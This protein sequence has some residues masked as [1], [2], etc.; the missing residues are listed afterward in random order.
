[1]NDLNTLIS[2]TDPL[3]PYVTLTSAVGINDS[4][5]ILANGVDSRTN[6]THAYLY[7]ASFIQLAPAALDFAH[8]DR[9]WDE[10][11]PVGHGN[12]R[13]YNCDPVWN[14]IGQRRFFVS[15]R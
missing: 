15:G 11:G 2:A 1:M 7:Q 6:L 10:S 5:L 3:K 4:L 12:E 13:W 9:W 8:M 14:P